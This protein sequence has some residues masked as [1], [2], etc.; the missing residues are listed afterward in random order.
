M[1]AMTQ[2]I[3]VNLTI[4]YVPHP[5]PER[6][7]ALLAELIL[8]QLLASGAGDPESVWDVKEV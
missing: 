2:E 6:G 8:K 1:S 3:T 5:N 4:N 7:I